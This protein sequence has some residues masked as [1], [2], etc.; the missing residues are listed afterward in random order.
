MED[1]APKTREAL[2]EKLQMFV[3]REAPPRVGQLLRVYC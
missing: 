3:F 2:V 1:F